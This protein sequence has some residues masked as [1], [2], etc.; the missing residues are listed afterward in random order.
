ME[1]RMRRAHWIFRSRVP[2]RGNDAQL[3]VT[4]Y[5]INSL[6]YV[7]YIRFTFCVCVQVL[8][9]MQLQSRDWLFVWVNSQFFVDLLLIFALCF[10]II[11][12][13]EYFMS[14]PLLDNVEICCPSH[15]K[16]YFL[17]N[18]RFH[19]FLWHI[20]SLIYL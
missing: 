6:Y 19:S 7:Y 10:V 12:K 5:D 17:Y 20:S 16:P 14:F 9:L 2:K 13:S 3:V 4:S 15:L 11:I 8:L 1:L 18:H